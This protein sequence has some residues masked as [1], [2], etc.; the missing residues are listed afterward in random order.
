[1]IRHYLKVAFRNTW[2]YKKQ[3]LISMVGLASG[4]ACFAPAT[5]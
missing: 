5:L 1:M 2:K 4:F 3:T